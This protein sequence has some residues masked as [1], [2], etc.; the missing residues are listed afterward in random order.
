MIRFALRCPNGHDFESWFANGAAF[1]RLRDS[2]HLSCAI[3]GAGGVE[4]ALMT[5]AVRTVAT[6]DRVPPAVVPAAAADAPAHQSGA[7]SADLTARIEALRREVEA[8]SEYV[9][10][11]FTAEARAIHLGEAP[12]RAIW[13]EA[14]LD[15]ARALHDEGVP[16]APLPFIPRRNTN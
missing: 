6:P 4:K 10:T 12:E 13:G 7:T 1:E 15:E 3:C 14:R 8:N 5:P 11:N 9:G 2:G 16:V